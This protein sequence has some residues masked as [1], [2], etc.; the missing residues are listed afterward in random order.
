MKITEI[1]HS[2]QKFGRQS[3]RETYLRRNSMDGVLMIQL[4]SFFLSVVK[5]LANR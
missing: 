5:D 4:K 2:A 1:F 3:N